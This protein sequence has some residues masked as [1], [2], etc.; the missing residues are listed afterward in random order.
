MINN[1]CYIFNNDIGT[2]VID[3]IILF[4]NYNLLDT[5]SIRFKEEDFIF[6]V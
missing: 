6:F 1:D 5:Q 3:K 4:I 2:Y